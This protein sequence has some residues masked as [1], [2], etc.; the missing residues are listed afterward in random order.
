MI[1]GL[2]SLVHPSIRQIVDASITHPRY[3]NLQGPTGALEE[4]AIIRVVTRREF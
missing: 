4:L 3:V 1:G 2:Q